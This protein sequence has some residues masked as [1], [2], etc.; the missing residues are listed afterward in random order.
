MKM[1][2]I[3]EAQGKLEA[4]MREVEA[5]ERIVL[6]RNGLPIVDLI[7]HQGEARRLDLSAPAR[8]RDERGLSELIGEPA[9]D[10]DEPLPEDFLL[11]PL[12]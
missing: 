3:T 2:P 5:G 12:H 8:I 1:V 6:T 4:L 9:A 10:F 7:A 11:R